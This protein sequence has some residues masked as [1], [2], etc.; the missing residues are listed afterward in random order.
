MAKRFVFFIFIFL[1]LFESPP[2]RSATLQDFEIDATSPTHEN[3]SRH[4]HQHREYR[5]REHR[6]DEDFF[7]ILFGD[8]IEEMFSDVVDVGTHVIGAAVVEGGSNSNS[9]LDANNS[10]P[11]KRDPGDPIIPFFRLNLNL[12]NISDNIYGFDGK[13]ETGY[14]ALAVEYRQTSYRDSEYNEQLKLKQIQFLYRMSFGSSVGVNM[15]FGGASLSGVNHSQG[16][17]ISLPMLYLPTRHIAF[18]FRPSW[19]FSDNLSIS[20]IDV[21]GLYAINHA[22][23]RIGYRELNSDVS[24]LY[25]AYLGLDYIF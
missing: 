3:A 5:H 2:T 23:I 13:L 18:E 19:L 15:G 20:E 6:R 21:S 10:S 14:G 17:L 4:D 22:A 25:G 8:L 12:Q 1:S 11:D 9:R 16:A 7:S 24:S